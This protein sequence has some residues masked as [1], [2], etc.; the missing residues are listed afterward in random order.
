M[1]RAFFLIMKQH[2]NNYTA[3]DLDVWKRLFERQQANLQ[4]KACDEYI[5]SLE[6]MK[7]VLNA[8]NLPNFDAINEWFVGG[9][10][11]SIHCVPGL[12]PV[13]EFFELLAD[14][15]FCSSTW[16]RPLSQLDYL[17]EPD[18][19]HDIFGHIPLLSDPI[20][21]EFAREFGKLGRSFSHD[22]ERVRMLQ[23]IYWFTIEF[24]LIRQEG[25]KI[26]GA[27]IISS[28]GESNLSVSGS[29]PV[30]DFDIERVMSTPFH[31]D[32]LQTHYVV[33]ESFEQL[34]DAILT[35]TKNWSTYA[36]ARKR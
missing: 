30:E 34:F 36:M 25:L 9:T 35:L 21:S 29:V 18:M 14:R 19:F 17:E 8:D 7:S 23:R 15:K 11:W 3:E 31:T 16:L 6:R 26:Y 27:G 22:P 32:Q 20:F 10:G 12:I 1:D 33:I 24:G 4:T 28:F 5:L 2:F 13:E